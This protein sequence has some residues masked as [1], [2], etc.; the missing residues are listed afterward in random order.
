[1]PKIVYVGD[2]EAVDVPSLSRTITKGE[3]ADV[4]DD[5]AAGLLSQPANWQPA[6]AA[7]GDS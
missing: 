1:M 5:E 4:S 2:E 3:P 6:K 7:K